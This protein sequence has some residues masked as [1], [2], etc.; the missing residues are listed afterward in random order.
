MKR[1][2]LSLFVMV[3]MVL[4][5]AFG[6]N[7][8]TVKEPTLSET[9]YSYDL[10]GTGDLD[11]SFDVGDY[12]FTSLYCAQF[13]LEEGAYSFDK[14][15][16]ALTIKSAYLH[17]LDLGS[18]AMSIVTTKGEY[19]FSLV[20]TDTTDHTPSFSQASYTYDKVGGE[21]LEMPLNTAGGTFYYAKLNDTI[22]DDR[23][24]SYDA[25][26]GLL[27]LKE[28]FVTALENGT[29]TL[30]AL[31]D[32]SETPATVTIVVEN[33]VVT[34][35]DEETTK[36]AVIGK[37]SQVQFSGSFVNTTLVGVEYNGQNLP[38]EWFELSDN[39]FTV[40]QEAFGIFS[41]KGDFVL[42]LSNYDQYE[43]SIV[44]NLVFYTDYDYTTIHD[45]TASN[46]GLNPLYQYYDN[47]S[48]V[49]APAGMSGK[50]LKITPNTADVQYDCNGYY[51]IRTDKC[52]YMWYQGSFS[53]GK[54]YVISF[55][56]MTKNTEG[57]G[58][59]TEFYFKNIENTKLKDDL[60]YGAENDNVVH[61]Y[62]AII[63][64]EDMDY[65]IM[66]RA[67]FKGGDGRGE[68]YVDN[69]R[70][71]EVDSVITVSAS[72]YTSGDY[73]LTID[74]KGYDYKLTYNGTELPYT[75][76]E[77][78][79]VVISAETMSAIPVGKAEIKVVTDLYAVSVIFRIVDNSTAQLQDKSAS[80]EY[81]NQQDVELSG[82]F[83]EGIT[84]V[85]F[86]QNAKTDDGTFGGWD[87]YVDND[88]D[89]KNNVVLTPG[90][91]GTGKLTIRKEFLAKLYGTTS[92]TVEYSN[93]AS[94]E[95]TI[96][97]DLN[98][99]SNYDESTLWGYFNGT[100]FD[101][102]PSPLASG[103]VGSIAVKEREPGNNSLYIY[104]TEG[105]LA[106]NY[107]TMR[108]HSHV[109]DW[110]QVQVDTT[111]LIRVTFT[112]QISGLAQ[113]SVYFSI[114]K[115]NDEI[116]ENNFF[117]AYTDE[118]QGAGFKEVRY[119]LNADGQ[120]HTF[121]S[122]WFTYNGDVRMTKISLPSFAQA[123]N[124]F[125]MLDDYTV[126]Q[127]ANPLSA[128][129]M[130]YTK[131]QESCSFGVSGTTFVSATING[132]EYAQ[133]SNGTVTLDTAKLDELSVG[134]YTVVVTTAI[135]TFKINLT[136]KSAGVANVFEPVQNYQYNSADMVFEGEFEGVT[137]ASATKKSSFKDGAT[138]FDRSPTELNLEH[139]VI[140]ADSLTVKKELLDKFY[141]TTGVM[142]TFSNG[143]VVELSIISDTL[144]FSNYDDTVIFNPQT[145]FTNG[146]DSQ[147]WTAL[148]IIDD[149]TGNKVLKYYTY[150]ATDL[151]KNTE[152]NLILIYFAPWSG[153]TEYTRVP[154]MTAEND[155]IVS[156]D[157][158]IFNTEGNVINYYFATMGSDDAWTKVPS[159]L[160]ASENSFSIKIKG[161]D[162]IR[163]FAVYSNVVGGYENCYMTIDN[164]RITVDHSNTA[165]AQL[166]ETS[167]NVV[168][169]A[170]ESVK[171][172]GEFDEGITVTSILRRGYNDWDNSNTASTCLAGEM[173]QMNTGY[174]TVERDGIVISPLLINQVY[175]TCD[176]IVKFSNE[177]SVAF[178]LTSNM[179]FFNNYD[180]TYV[181]QAWNGSQNIVSCQ[182]T[183]M[184]EIVGEENRRLKYDCNLAVFPWSVG[185]DNR[186]YTFSVGSHGNTWW[187]PYALDDTKTLIVTFDYELVL[188]EK[189][190]VY[191]F[192][193]WDRDNNP[194][195]VVLDPAK[196]SFSIELPVS[197]VNAFAIA[198]VRNGNEQNTHMY[199]DNFGFGYKA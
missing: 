177:K 126:S 20:I 124:T 16:K 39:A 121:D 83:S 123:E 174:I 118:V 187:W 142:L 82:S 92:F 176:Y 164:Y 58:A 26:N 161:G 128:S 141:G 132:E 115:S 69:F 159:E 190:A 54:Y 129:E 197:E 119:M 144:Y 41:G 103:F 89:Y 170:S 193:Y 149:Q 194:H 101:G 147:D 14:A 31:T 127:I 17:T 29:Y 111:K 55:D 47:V 7:P 40:K 45:T 136:V 60:L 59:A 67:F 71:A 195:D 153:R 4:L 199:I 68:V 167:K 106:Y 34:S 65:G 163:G 113:D 80:F 86:K 173:K 79:T 88:K 131:G 64:Y 99:T 120:V 91:E 51:T 137:L 189:D 76:G 25:S 198:C 183:T 12:E 139:F 102:H 9:S 134:K 24:V 110:Y 97:S 168:Y 151:A 179:L 27:V 13:A 57:C 35:F 52:P 32:L 70:I 155:Y 44:N 21:D 172:A 105:S 48:I 109:W 100:P 90:L 122:G 74:D 84:V 73:V 104:S 98:V 150:G 78:N 8:T 2:H 182:D 185:V 140:S 33:S 130:E 160:I 94:E 158:K 63:S 146:Y 143:D 15:A 107:F 28:E 85:S 87:F 175:G 46:L 112:Y 3:A 116:T 77:N 133:E 169:G 152:N 138:E 36:T 114:I 178:S 154:N 72:N 42:H 166:T 75:K 196:T 22:I 50:A 157:Y 37:D 156:F 66:L 53:S 117:G 1:N 6:C 180:E 186:V 62:S 19:G 125:I 23:Y 93:G 188:N 165:T 108:F 192:Q 148:S 81:Y 11:V 181:V 171:L 5:L 49:D 43:F 184:I 10:V 56:Y 38:S 145:P 61:H 18:Y 135:G 30:T 95:I 96:T 191:A 162:P